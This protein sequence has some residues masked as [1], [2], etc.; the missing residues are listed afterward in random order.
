LEPTETVDAVVNRPLVAPAHQPERGS[1]VEEVVL[2]RPFPNKVPGVLGIVPNRTTPVAVRG[3]ERVIIGLLELAL[4]VSHGVCVVARREGHKAD[5][6]HTAIRR[7][8]E[9]H[10]IDTFTAAHFPEGPAE[11]DIS[12]GV[13]RIESYNVDRNLDKIIG[14]NACGRLG[15][16]KLSRGG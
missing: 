1:A 11:I 7:V 5:T 4:P 14:F 2:S 9:A 8:A 13:A 6:K 3:S 15:K 16:G 10:N 12:K